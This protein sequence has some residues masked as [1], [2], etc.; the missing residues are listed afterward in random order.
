MTSTIPMNEQ[1]LAMLLLRLS[2]LFCIAALLA[3]VSVGCAVSQHPTTLGK[4][5]TPASSDAMLAL[6]DQPGPIAMEKVLAANW[7]VIRSGLI[8]LDHPA[9]KQAK[10]QDGDEAIEIYFYVLRHPEFGTYIVDSGLEAGF[11]EPDSSPRLRPSQSA[12][13]TADTGV[14]LLASFN[15]FLHSPIKAKHVRRLVHQGI[16]L[17]SRDFE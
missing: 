2:F 14:V 10:L 6:V 8:N 17:V 15:R 4:L 16:E 11:R 9:A 3:V 5:G 1:R 13:A 7:K 12:L